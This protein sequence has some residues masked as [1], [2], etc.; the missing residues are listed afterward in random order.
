ML[1]VFLSILF[2]AS[3][4]SRSD[5]IEESLIA[6]YLKGP[7]R[8]FCLRS[9]LIVVLFGWLCANGSAQESWWAGFG[10]AE[11]TPGTSAI[12]W[13]LESRQATYSSSGSSLR[14]SHGVT[15]VRPIPKQLDTKQTGQH[16]VVL[17][18]I[19]SIA[20]VGSSMR[21]NRRDAQ[22]GVWTNAPAT[23]SFVRRIHTQRSRC[24]RPQ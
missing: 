16:T 11:I 8:M 10:K 14:Q 4:P 7:H 3:S 19:D 21:V 6:P 5:L 15:T 9:L 2:F 1:S 17:V 13:L 23:L 24:L 22:R 20:I 12:E 18:S